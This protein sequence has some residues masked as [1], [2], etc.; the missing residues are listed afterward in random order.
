MDT[1]KTN[2]SINFYQGIGSEIALKILVQ[3]QY[4]D[5]NLDSKCPWQ[6]GAMGPIPTR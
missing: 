5:L 3:S 1:N 6:A 4:R 2:N